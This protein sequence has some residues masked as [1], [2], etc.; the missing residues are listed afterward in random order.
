MTDTILSTDTRRAGPRKHTPMRRPSARSRAGARRGSVYLLVLSVSMIVLVIGLSGLMVSRIE[1]RSA[2]A[3]SDMT[4]AR[5][6]ALAAIEMGMFEIE[7]YPSSWRDRFDAGILPTDM[8][9]GNGYLTLEAADPVDGDLINNT[10]DPVLFT[11]I[12]IEGGAR[13]KLQVT[14]TFTGGVTEFQPRSWKQV[15]D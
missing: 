2:S 13:H 15:V 1:Q 4:Q 8:P 9:L 11:G 14:I 12:G 3:V 5:L 7:D 6:H 10:V